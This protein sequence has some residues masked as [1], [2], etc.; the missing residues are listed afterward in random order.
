YDWPLL[1]DRLTIHR[2]NSEISTK[3]HLD[4]LH[5]S[6]RVWKNSLSDCSLGTIERHIL[7]V[8]RNGDIPAYLIPHLYFQYLRSKDARPLKPVFYHNKMDILSLVTLTIKLFEIHQS[9]TLQLKNCM[10]LLT[11]ARHYESM[12][13]WDK[14]AL[15][16][17][18]ILQTE[19]DDAFME[20]HLRLAQCFKKMGEF[21]AAESVWK[22]LI[23]TGKL[24]IEAIEELA[25]Y[26]EHQL[27]DIEGAQQ[28]V[29]SALQ[30]IDCLEQLQ[31]DQVLLQSK[32]S[33]H[34]RLQRLQRKLDQQ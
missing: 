4:L 34:H 11:L 31:H 33:L 18:T 24:K 20:I 21:E 22:S 16:Y 13:L 17:K 15:L 6:R 10:D 9:P 12:K 30:R 5:A 19:P 29:L 32:I 7:N 3:L 25:K 26:Y 1:K 27:K 23:K 2:L 28:I 8:F 14:A